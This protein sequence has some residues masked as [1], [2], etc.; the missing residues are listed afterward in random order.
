MHRLNEMRV[1]GIITQ[2]V[3]Q[4]ANANFED[5]VAY[6]SLRPHRLKQGLF[7]QQ[8]P[9]GFHKAPQDGKGFWPQGKRLCQVP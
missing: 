9:R 1:P 4:F 7:G 3:S 5:H 8:L 2:G 6:H